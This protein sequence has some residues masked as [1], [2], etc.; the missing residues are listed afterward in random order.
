MAASV[1]V[2]AAAKIIALHIE[3]RCKA[4]MYVPDTFFE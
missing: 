3:L 1:F 4:V 2:N